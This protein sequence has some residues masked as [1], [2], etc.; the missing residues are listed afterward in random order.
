LFKLEQKLSCK[1]QRKE[2]H[3]WFTIFPH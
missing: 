2:M 3:S 1:L